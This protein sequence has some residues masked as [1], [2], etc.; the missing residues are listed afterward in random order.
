MPIHSITAT[1]TS[2]VPAPVAALAEAALSLFS[3]VPLPAEAAVP[4]PVE[5]VVSP[6]VDAVV[7]PPVEAVSLV[8]V[9]AAGAVTVQPSGNLT[10]PM[11]PSLKITLPVQEASSRVRVDPVLTVIVPVFLIP[12]AYAVLA[13]FM[14]M[15]AALSMLYNDA[16]V[17]VTVTTPP[18]EFV[19]PDMK[20]SLPPVTETGP[21]LTRSGGRE[22]E[23]ERRGGRRRK[24]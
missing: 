16:A 15:S 4:P 6:P 8:C 23:T 10:L 20:M 24:T 5:A 13:P 9:T 11:A 14:V 21:E 17:S 19:R 1:A 3:A 22:R 7:P 18:T 12:Y 2:V